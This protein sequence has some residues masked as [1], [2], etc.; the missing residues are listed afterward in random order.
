MAVSK[1]LLTEFGIHYRLESCVDPSKT[2]CEKKSL[3]TETFLQGERGERGDQG[4]P[5]PAGDP[6]LRGLP[7]K[8]G[9]DGQPG[10]P[11]IKCIKYVLR[12]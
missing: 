5:G 2:R 12:N 11:G 10:F 8:T 4:Q 9:S 1:P 6:G 7:G 3:L